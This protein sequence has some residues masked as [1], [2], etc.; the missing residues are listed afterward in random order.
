V[1]GLSRT[2]APTGSTVRHWTRE[3]VLGLDWCCCSRCSSQDGWTRHWDA[4]GGGSGADQAGP[5][6]RDEA[7]AG[8]AALAAADVAEFP[9]RRGAVRHR[10]V[11]DR[12]TA[13]ATGQ[14]GISAAAAAADDDDLTFEATSF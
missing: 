2:R 9:A 3:F 10:A 11:D 7:A 12:S 5:G 14:L 13:C 4:T 8:G 6:R 1:H